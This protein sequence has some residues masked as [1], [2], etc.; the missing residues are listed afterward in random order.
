MK[1]IFYFDFLRA[2]AIIGIIFCHASTQFVVLD[3]GSVN[4]YFSAFFDCFRDFCVPAFVM[5]SGALLIG[6]KDSLISFFK[7]RLSR[8]FIPFLFWYVI[9][10]IY[11]FFKIKHNI[12]LNNALNIFLGK[13]GTLGVAFWFIWM[14]IIVYLAIF[15]INKIIEFGDRKTE[16]FKDKFLKILTVLS[17]VYIILYQFNFLPDAI[18]KQILGYYISFISYAIIGYFIANNDFIQKRIDSTKLALI[19]LILFAFSYIYYII[20]FVVAKSLIYNHFMYLSY[21]NISILFISI[22]FFL[23]FKYSSETQFFKKL[24]NS[25]YGDMVIELSKYSY[26]IYLA[27]YVVL[28]ELKR[29]VYF[30]IG[31]NY[32]NSIIAIPAYVLVTLAITVAIL[33]VLNRIP[34]INRISGKA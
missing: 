13:S 12:D 30:N 34:Y 21:F 2:L 31:S 29:F 28:F 24:E 14:I 11:S 17:L 4:F 10:V 3:I 9:Y 16:G 19:T 20:N 27:H 15:A 23:M 7:K 32:M 18:Y 5:L 26:G 6:K 8:I 1:R 33:W 22:C 25:K